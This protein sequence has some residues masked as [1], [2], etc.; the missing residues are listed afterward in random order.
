MP[1]ITHAGGV[2]ARL[3][4][5]RAGAPDLS[6]LDP[7]AIPAGLLDAA[8][9]AW[10]W[11]A[12]TELRSAQ[13][14]ARFVSEVL[15]AGDPLEVWTGAADAVVDEVRHVA[16]CVAVVERLGG[17]AALPEPLAEELATAFLAAPMAQRA[18]TTAISLHAV[19]ETLSVAL[20]EDLRGRCRHPAIR[21]VLDATVADEADHRAYGWA[22]VQASLARFDEGDLPHW[23]HVTRLAL[24]PHEARIARV[25]ADVPAERRQLESWPEPE[26]ADLGLLSP[27]REALL[28]RGALDELVL[29]RL[30]ALSLV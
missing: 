13:V 30:R 11:R 3:H 26:L 14:M 22:Y 21:A 20:I 6:A 29:P 16:L 25:L 15:T 17:A 10:A 1:V 27:Q 12:Q 8:R 9:A 5:A 24:E 2:F 18:L 7:A 19:A 4:E 28:L 23:R